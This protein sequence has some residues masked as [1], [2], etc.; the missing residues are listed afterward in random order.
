MD[1]LSLPI[2][3]SAMANFV[4]HDNLFIVKNLV[5]DA[6]IAHTQLVESCQIT[7]EWLWSDVIK[8]RG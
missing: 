5:D 6:V 1:A 8:I 2:D 7:R 3:F 4:N